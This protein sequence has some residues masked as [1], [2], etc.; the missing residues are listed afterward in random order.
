MTANL[1]RNQSW[2]K[3][4]TRG[5]RWGTSYITLVKKIILKKYSFKIGQLTSYAFSGHTYPYPSSSSQVPVTGYLFCQIP[6]SQSFSDG[7]TSR[8]PKTIRKFR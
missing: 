6:T 8:W 4:W 5:T 2:D 7:H 1:F 3:E